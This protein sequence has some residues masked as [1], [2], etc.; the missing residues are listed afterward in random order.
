MSTFLI[1]IQ[2]T[3]LTV[4]NLNFCLLLHTF[5]NVHYDRSVD[6]G[7]KPVLFIFHSYNFGKT[8]GKKSRMTQFCI[9]DRFEHKLKEF[10]FCPGV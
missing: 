10:V 1:I 7:H 3:V 8:I 4:L 2:V 6:A 9:P 5:I